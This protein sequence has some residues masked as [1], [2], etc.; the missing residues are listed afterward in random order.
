MVNYEK[1]WGI[2]K[3]ALYYYNLPSS[4]STPSVI[5]STSLCWQYVPE[6]KENRMKLMN[7]S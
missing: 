4:S 1:L 5:A 6:I 7:I 3:M 2:Y